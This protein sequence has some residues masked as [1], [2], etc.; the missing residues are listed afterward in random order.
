MARQALSSRGV[1]RAVLVSAGPAGDGREFEPIPPLSLRRKPVREACNLPPLQ[2]PYGAH[3]GT[4][5]IEPGPRRF[6][7]RERHLLPSQLDVALLR[8]AAGGLGDFAI[9]RAEACMMH[10]H[11]PA[12]GP[13]LT[14][15]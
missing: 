2:P 7:R 10:T 4:Q 11:R 13:M 9:P 12:R 5:L 1:N 8:S 14:I 15:N 6:G 3:L